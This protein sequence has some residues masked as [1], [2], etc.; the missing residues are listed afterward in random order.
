MLHF[1]FL[2]LM[3]CLFLIGISAFWLFMMSRKNF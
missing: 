1:L 3:M 2:F